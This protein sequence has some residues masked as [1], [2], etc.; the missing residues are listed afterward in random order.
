MTTV[1]GALSFSRKEHAVRTRHQHP[2]LL[3]AITGTA[4]RPSTLQV[5]ELCADNDRLIAQT[6]RAFEP[7]TARAD[8]LAVLEQLEWLFEAEAI[9]EDPTKKEDRERLARDLLR[10]Y[11]ELH[12]E[13]VRSKRRQS[14]VFG[15]L[16][17]SLTAPFV[18]VLEVAFRS[19]LLS[20]LYA[21]LVAGALL[22][23]AA[24]LS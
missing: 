7:D 23:L 20:L 1:A 22:L 5:I 9:E 12:D 21:L 8:R 19:L 16:V 6:L 24:L 10:L 2:G 4:R 11:D 13:E 14:A 3:E 17:H 18:Y 15:G